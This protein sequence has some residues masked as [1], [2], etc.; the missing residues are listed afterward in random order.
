[1]M[2]EHS[3]EMVRGVVWWWCSTVSAQPRE[4]AAHRGYTPAH[5]RRWAGW[6]G[7]TSCEVFTSMSVRSRKVRWVLA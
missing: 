5:T 2:P 7:V 4:H 1:M 6:R 3:L